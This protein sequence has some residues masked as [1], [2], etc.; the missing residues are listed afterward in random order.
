MAREA[1]YI[2]TVVGDGPYDRR[3]FDALGRSLDMGPDY[4]YNYNLLYQMGI[5][6]NV[7]FITEPN[8]RG[9]EDHG[10]A[11]NAMRWML[12]DLTAAE[13][14]RLGRYLEEHLVRE[15]G[16]W[17]LDYDRAIRWAV[18]WWRK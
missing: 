2:S 17:R 6:A 15:N 13:E 12:D 16:G 9:F 18:I 10:D 5:R 11:L 8:N 4:I 1:V 3:V 7:E 14:E